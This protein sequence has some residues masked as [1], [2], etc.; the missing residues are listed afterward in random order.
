MQ[1]HHIASHTCVYICIYIYIYIYMA[2]NVIWDCGFS[3][4][5]LSVWI[6]TCYVCMYLL[7]AMNMFFHVSVSRNPSILASYIL[8]VCA[9]NKC[10]LCTQF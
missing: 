4:E 5:S 1:L 2:V 7:V 3:S 8:P 9:W 6:P 10:I